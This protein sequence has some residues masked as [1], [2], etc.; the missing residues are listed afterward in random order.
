MNMFIFRRSQI[1]AKLKSNQSQIV[2]LISLTTSQSSRS[3]IATVIATSVL[4]LRLCLFSD[5]RNYGS[6][7]QAN[8]NFPDF[9]LFHWLSRFSSGRP[10]CNKSTKVKIQ[11]DIIVSSLY[12]HFCLFSLFSF[13]LGCML[14]VVFNP[15]CPVWFSLL[16][17]CI[18]FCFSVPNKTIRT[19]SESEQYGKTITE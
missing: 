16:L 12:W 2:I 13:V 6:I 3:R 15:L 7:S 11:C 10:P 4:R 1:E 9:S 5:H 14:V 17:Y 19:I 8:H 18:Y